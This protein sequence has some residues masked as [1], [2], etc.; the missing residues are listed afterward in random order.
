MAT[1]E[2]ALAETDWP[3]FRALLAEAAAHDG[4]RLRDG[5]SPSALGG[6][7]DREGGAHVAYKQW[8]WS[9]P[10]EERAT[11]YVVAPNGA[12]SPAAEALLDRLRAEWPVAVRS[13]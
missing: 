12:G 8:R 3:R 2:L 11:L 9:H 10:R 4:W 5:S 6:S 1:A 7:L 13:G